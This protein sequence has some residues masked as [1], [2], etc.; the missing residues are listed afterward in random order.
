MKFEE[1]EEEETY[2]Q[3]PMGRSSVRIRASNEA[4]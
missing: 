1:K 4:A 3:I 2:Y